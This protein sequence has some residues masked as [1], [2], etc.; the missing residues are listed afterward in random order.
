M[1]F[2]AV[3]TKKSC[4][5]SK[6]LLSRCSHL[7]SSRNKHF[8]GIVFQIKEMFAPFKLPN[9]T[10]CSIMNRLLTSINQGL[11]KDTHSTAPVKCFQTYICDF[12]SGNGNFLLRISKFEIL[13]TLCHFYLPCSTESGKF[14]AVDF[15]GTNFRILV[16]T[17]EKGRSYKVDSR[18]YVFPDEKLES[19]SDEVGLNPN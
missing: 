13:R 17:L 5:V 19:E 2:R 10:L 18:I 4:V 15:G 6:I 11:S 1:A 7:S 9:G 3:G 16:I 12:P 8:F 14:L